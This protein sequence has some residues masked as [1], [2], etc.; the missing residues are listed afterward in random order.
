MFDSEK[1]ID[2]ENLFS[3]DNEYDI[4][5]F[6]NG[7]ILVIPDE[8]S[9]DLDVE[10]LSEDFIDYHSK[11]LQSMFFDLKDMSYMDRFASNATFSDLC[12][13]I[14]YSKHNTSDYVS[15]KNQFDT[16][17]CK[18]YNCRKISLKSFIQHFY[19]E[20]MEHYCYFHFNF[21]FNLGYFRDWCEFCFMYSDINILR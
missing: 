8:N 2:D 10:T 5:K 4:I 13:Y 7:K 14:I 11:E 9:E 1:I 15:W 19:K 21:S 3:Y 16:F 18:Y 20:L 17:S 6:N 12:E